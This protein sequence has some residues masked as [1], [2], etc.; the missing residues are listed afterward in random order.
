VH[1]TSKIGPFQLCEVADVGDVTINAL[2]LHGSLAGIE[3]FFRQLHE[4]RIT[5]IAVGGCRSSAR[6]P[7]TGRWDWCSSTRFCHV[8]RRLQRVAL[9]EPSDYAICMMPIAMRAR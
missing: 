3:A 9:P 2:D 7:V 1:P 6:S 5:P 8:S 4:A